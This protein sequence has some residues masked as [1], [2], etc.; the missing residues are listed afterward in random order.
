MDESTYQSSPAPHLPENPGWKA[1]LTGWGGC[2]GA[3]AGPGEGRH[4]PLICNRPLAKMRWAQSVPSM[5]PATD[6]PQAS[7]WEW[8]TDNRK[9]GKLAEKEVLLQPRLRL[10]HGV[11][12]SAR[13][14]SL[15]LLRCHQGSRGL[16]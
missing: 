16:G 11:K 3:F 4:K 14:G 12:V 9:A 1:G 10:G 2:R 13:V 6:L 15:S 8:E 5:F 7:P